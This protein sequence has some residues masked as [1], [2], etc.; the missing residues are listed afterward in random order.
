MRG[1]KR[2]R[3]KKAKKIAREALA[4][5]QDM[6]ELAISSGYLVEP[7]PRYRIVKENMESTRRQRKID[8][9]AKKVL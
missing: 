3:K 4:T 8:I 1:R 7:L 9:V 5:L 2:L 6:F